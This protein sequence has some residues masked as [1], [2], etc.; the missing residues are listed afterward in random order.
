MNFKSE[1][2]NPLMFYGLKLWILEEAQKS[3]YCQLAR[4]VLIQPKSVIIFKLYY[5][6][7]IYPYHSLWRNWPKV[8]DPQN[9]F[10]QWWNLKKI[11]NDVHAV[12]NLWMSSIEKMIC[13]NAYKICSF[14]AI[15]PT[16]VFI[17]C[18]RPKKFQSKIT[19]S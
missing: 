3:S 10:H 9:Q 16:L 2:S 1:F 7:D 13:I 18:W 17:W 11:V 6:L 12:S 14:S 4:S 8:C 15:A 5:C 19:Q